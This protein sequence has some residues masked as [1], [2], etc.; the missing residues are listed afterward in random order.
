MG[1]QLNKLIQDFKNGENEKF[2]QIIEKMKPLINKYIRLLYKDEKEDIQSEFVLCLLESITK[3]KYYNEEGQCIYFLSKALKNRFHELYKKSKLHFDREVIVD[4][5]Y[6]ININFKQ[7][8]YDNC[9]ICEDLKKLLL[10]TEGKQYKILY[11]MIFNDESDTEIAKKL[12][13]SRQYVNRIRK[14]SYNLLKEKY[15]K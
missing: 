6:F 15:F 4:D 8:E 14:N 10:K 9:I 3:M 2:I 7:S 11:A 1:D 5:E 13:V 12:F